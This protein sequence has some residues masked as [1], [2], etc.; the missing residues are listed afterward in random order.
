[1]GNVYFILW[2]DTGSLCPIRIRDKSKRVLRVGR[3]RLVLD[4]GCLNINDRL[5]LYM[6]GF[7]VL[8]FLMGFA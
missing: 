8:A 7:N 4:I 2:K 3:P 6:I 1:M 5:A